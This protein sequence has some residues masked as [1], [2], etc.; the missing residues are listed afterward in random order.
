[1]PTGPAS[2]LPDAVPALEPGV[3]LLRGGPA[4]LHRVVVA[5]LA[6]GRTAALWVDPGRAV[7]THALYELAPSK[8]PL[9][10]LRVARAF[11]AYQHH[12]LVREL[13]SRASSRTQLVVLPGVGQL[14]RDDDVPDYEREALFEA[15]VSV[16]AELAASLTIPVLLGDDGDGG[17]VTYIVGW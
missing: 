8:R 5:E 6:R 11:T 16:G 7:S 4:A 14:Y 12:A 3:T 15:A 2:P 17:P 13:V 10:G 1:M 9:A